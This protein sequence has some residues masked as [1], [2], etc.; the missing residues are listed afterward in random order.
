MRWERSTGDVAMSAPEIRRLAVVIAADLV[1]FTR[2]MGEDEAAARAAIRELKATAFEPVVERHGGEILK[3]LGDGWI[4]A[5]PSATAAVRAAMA[6]QTGLAEHRAIRL[7]LGAHLGELVFDDSDFH[8]QSV[9]LAA[10]LQ[11]EAPPGGLLVSQDVH[12]QLDAALARE[13]VDAGGFALK[14]VA[15]AVTGYRWRPTPRGTTG[16]TTGGNEL[17]VIAVDDLAPTPDDAATRAAAEDV[18]APLI[19]RL[20]RRTGIRVVDARTGRADAATYLLRGRLRLAHGRGRLNLAMLRERDGRPVWSQTY[21]RPAADPF[22]FADDLVDRV[23]ADLRVQIN[24]FDAERIAELADA[25]LS[26][27]ELRAR[28]ASAYYEATLASWERALALVERAL[29]LSPEDPMA[30]AMRVEG[31][32]MLAAARFGDLDDATLAALDAG[33]DLAVERLPRSDYVFFARGLLRV[34]ARRDATAARR[35]AERTRALGPAYA[36]AF[37]LDGLVHLLD[38]AFDDAAASFARAVALS[39]DDPLLPYRQYLQA[40]ALY[41]RGERARARAVIEPA[42]ELRPRVWGFHRLRAL[43]DGDARGVGPA[44]APSI[45]APRPPLPDEGAELVA[46][47]T[48]TSAG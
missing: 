44:S 31:A 28:A 24:A 30:L 36:P 45:L 33:S 9:N 25:E 10:R 26:V 37:E 1:G 42:I 12:R 38:G 23:D 48:P 4:V 6:V 15:L 8:G 18:R 3:R 47:L 27:S 21:D 34:Y 29:E 41:A 13:F 17:P 16:R 11:T 43:A 19:E 35:D 40:V 46:A 2:W 22:A 14:H 32:V 7:R 20:A 5:F 39:A